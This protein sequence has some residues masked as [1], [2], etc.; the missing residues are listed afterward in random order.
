MDDHFD[1][2]CVIKK[3]YAHALALLLCSVTTFVEDSG[4]EALPMDKSPCEVRQLHIVIV[5]P[6]HEGFAVPR[7]VH[8]IGQQGGAFARKT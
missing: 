2:E 7:R 4:L 3:I 1:A 6:L 5:S 8:S